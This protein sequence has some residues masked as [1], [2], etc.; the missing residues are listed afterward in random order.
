MPKSQL[1][2]NHFLS[3]LRFYHGRAT[4]SRN[5]G[6]FLSDPFFYDHPPCGE[7]SRATDQLKR[8]VLTSRFPISTGSV[9]KTSN[10][11]NFYGGENLW[12]DS[13]WHG[14]EDD[15]LKVESKAFSGSSHS[16]RD[17][18]ASLA[19]EYAEIDTL[20]TF[21]APRKAGGP[22]LSPGEKPAEAYATSSILQAC[23]KRRNHVNI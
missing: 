4:S 18:L 8:T 13:G 11:A 2:E 23:T 12:T 3:L 19:P 22:L 17:L 5:F 9:T 6:V 14:N 1:S 21:G 20:G 10:L 16:Q 15:L 7:L